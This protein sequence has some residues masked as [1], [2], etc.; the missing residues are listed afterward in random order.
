MAKECELSTA[1]LLL[2]GLPKNSVVRITDHFDMTSAVYHES[3]KQKQ[4]INL[5]NLDTQNMSRVM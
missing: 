4:T 5:P 3:Y 2:G 1:K